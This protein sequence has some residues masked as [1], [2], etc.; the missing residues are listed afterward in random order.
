[1]GIE[2]ID[3]V[4]LQGDDLILVGEENK[5]KNNEIKEKLNYV[6]SQGDNLIL[7]G[8]EN[9]N[10]LHEVKEIVEDLTNTNL[11]ELEEIIEDVRGELIED[12][13]YVRLQGDDLILIGEENKNKN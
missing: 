3:Y 7:I 6:E 4:R 10:K 13:D 8:E 1:M 12:I 9:K 11:T 5:N 2:D